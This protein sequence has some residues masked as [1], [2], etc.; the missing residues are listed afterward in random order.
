MSESK[1]NE[2]DGTFTLRLENEDSLSGEKH[3]KD[4]RFLHPTVWMVAEDNENQ[5]VKI[6]KAVMLESREEVK[7]ENLEHK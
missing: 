2:L 7:K 1:F 4:F 3:V 5:M 6:I